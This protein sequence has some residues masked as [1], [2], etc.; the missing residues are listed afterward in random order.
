MVIANSP[1]TLT[2]L[3]NGDRLDRLEF[4]RRYTAS[5]IKNRGFSELRLMRWEAVLKLG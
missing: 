5:N 4:E 2:I 1:P 3:E